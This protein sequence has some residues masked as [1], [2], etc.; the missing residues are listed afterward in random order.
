MNLNKSHYRVRD[1][2]FQRAI[3]AQASLAR[4]HSK[5]GFPTELAVKKGTRKGSGHKPLGTMADVAYI[6]SIHEFGLPSRNIPQRSFFR[7]AIEE[8]KVKFAE[9]QKKLLGQ[10]LDG[11]LA[12][13]Q[14]LGLLGEFMVAR[15]KDRIRKGQYAPLSPKTIARKRS[16]KPLIDTAQ[17]INSVQHIEYVR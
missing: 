9:L 15:I 14:G 3:D 6:A 7:P 4:S 13:M 8:N 1:F 16:D 5:V 2:G 17:M 12:V 11:K 10:V